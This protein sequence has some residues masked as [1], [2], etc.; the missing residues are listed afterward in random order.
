MA[1]MAPS[2]AKTKVPSKS[3]VRSNLAESYL[4]VPRSWPATTFVDLRA[5]VLK[6]V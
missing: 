2:T 1:A 5:F 4:M 6:K 3:M